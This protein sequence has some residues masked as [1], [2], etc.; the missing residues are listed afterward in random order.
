[1][2]VAAIRG[3]PDLARRAFDTVWITAP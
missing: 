2:D 3:E 1:M